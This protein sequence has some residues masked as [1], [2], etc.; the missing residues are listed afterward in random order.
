[1]K[2]Y[3]GFC[4]TLFIFMNNISYGQSYECDN[5]YGDCGTPN[6]SGGGG[7]GG[8]SVLIANTDLGDTYQNADD[9]D[10]D[11]V[12]DTS[13][14]C[15]RL[16]NP[17]QLD[18]DGDGVGDACDNCIY[19]HNTL[20]K[21][22]DYDGFGDVCDDDDDDDGLEDFEDLCPKQWGDSC[23]EDF[24]EQLQEWPDYNYEE[25]V[26]TKVKEKRKIFNRPESCDSSSKTSNTLLFLLTILAV[27]SIIILSKNKK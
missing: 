22:N 27:L 2:A 21:D 23:N 14:N 1:M 5:N 18:H 15:M 13:D 8:G 6:Q 3:F 7:G 16:S 24:D 19:I 4:L 17:Y 11:G 25:S 12:E 26:E 9:F 20:Q 10:D